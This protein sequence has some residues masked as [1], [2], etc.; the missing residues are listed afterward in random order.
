MGGRYVADISDLTA[1]NMDEHPFSDGWRTRLFGSYIQSFCCPPVL[2]HVSQRSRQVVLENYETSFSN[3][4][5]PDMRM[6]YEAVY[7]FGLEWTGDEDGVGAEFL[8]KERPLL[9]EAA[10]FLPKSVMGNYLVASEEKAPTEWENV[11]RKEEYFEMK[12]L[13]FERTKE[14]FEKVRTRPFGIWFRPTW[15]TILLRRDDFGTESTLLSLFKEGDSEAGNVRSFAIDEYLIGEDKPRVW[16]TLLYVYFPS[17]KTPI[18]QIIADFEYSGRGR[19][20]RTTAGIDSDDS[21]ETTGDEVKAD[22]KNPL[23]TGLEELIV[24]VSVGF[25]DHQPVQ[26]EAYVDY[27]YEEVNELKQKCHDRIIFRMKNHSALTKIPFIKIERER[28]M[29]GWTRYEEPLQPVGNVLDWFHR[30]HK[31]DCHRVSIKGKLPVG[32]TRL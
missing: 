10:A 18:S 9:E 30:V 16:D 13:K 19:P 31:D 1:P 2:L 20:R 25:Y 29:Y 26:N 6:F 8:E 15:D 17:P 11:G 21:D 7:A 24:I 4:S 14:F 5:S 12:K 32:G 28:D 3:N 23:L 22:T 27:A